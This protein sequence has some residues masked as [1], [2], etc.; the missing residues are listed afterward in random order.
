MSKNVVYILLIIA[1]LSGCKNSVKDNLISKAN[2]ECGSQI[3][4]ACK[5]ALKDVTKFQW[6]KVY[7]SRLDYV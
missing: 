4:S 5:I 7:I 3:K 1:V 6:D 2:Q